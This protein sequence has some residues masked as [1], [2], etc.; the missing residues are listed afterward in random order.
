M[1]AA[2]V[3]SLRRTG[4]ALKGPTAAA[5]EGRTPGVGAALRAE[6]DLYASVRPCRTWPGATARG[7]VPLDVVVIR[8][9]APAGGAER[10][11]P[12]HRRETTLLIDHL[13][14]SAGRR[15]PP[16]CGLSLE[17]AT[18]ENARRLLDFA[19]DY[20]VRHGRR[21]VAAIHKATRRP[22]TDGVWL[23]ALAET[24]RE[25]PQLQC[26]DELIDNACARL[27]ERPGAFD[28]L[29][30]PDLYGDILADLATALAGG[31][32]TAAGGHFGEGTAI[33]EPVH[34]CAAKL[35][36]KDRANPAATIVAGAMLLRH[37]GATAAADRLEAALA[38]TL[39]AGTSA[40]IVGTR[41]FG[42]AVMARLL[43]AGGA[44]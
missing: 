41:G 21:R 34:G 39:A 8:E 3:S 32:G 24:A 26:G 10:E 33:F 14:R 17:T 5:R 30:A 28:V 7:G 44:G 38:E 25:Y 15:F 40:G 22:A 19:C 11:F 35:H 6:F 4:V 37:V 29:A 13:Q 2:L 9:N 23:A 43:P 36:G 42:Q 31:L 18:R 20:A 1:P 16:G 12:P 27:V